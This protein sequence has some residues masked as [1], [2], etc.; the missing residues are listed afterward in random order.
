MSALILDI[1]RGTPAARALTAQ[2]LDR[3]QGHLRTGIK[4]MQRAGEIAPG[5]DASRVAGALVAGIQG[6]VTILLATG[7]ITNLEAALDLTIALLKSSAAHPFEDP[8]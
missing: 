3:W 8:V 4:T 7:E 2:L 6:G 1:G 5:I